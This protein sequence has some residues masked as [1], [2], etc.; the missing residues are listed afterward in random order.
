MVGTAKEKDLP[1]IS[2]LVSGTMRRFLLEDLRDSKR[3]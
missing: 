2:D 1:P 3:M